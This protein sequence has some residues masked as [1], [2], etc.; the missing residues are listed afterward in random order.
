MPSLSASPLSRR[1][2]GQG[3]GLLGADG[4]PAADDDAAAGAEMQLPSSQA[5]PGDVATITLR[6]GGMM[7]NGCRGKV[8]RTLAAVEG[9]QSASVDLE[10]ELAQVSGSASAAALIAA[11][12][13]VGKSAQ[14]ASPEPET[15]ALKIGGMMCNGC[16]GKVE[17][18]L[19]AVQGV[20]SASVVLETELAHVT[21]T[22]SAKELIAAVEAVGKTA[23]LPAP[24]PETITL[25]I[26]GMVR[27]STRRHR[28]CL[29]PSPAAHHLLLLLPHPTLTP[30]LRRPSDPRPS[31]APTDVQ[32]LPRQG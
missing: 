8:E 24:E 13:A 17:K 12:E 22:A 19:A 26:G 3:Y 7:C 23:Q 4:A 1:R 20:Q 5:G 32:R 10:S 16:R 21:G 25:K 6:I 18:A 11:V 29:P 9:V 31:H 28:P 2:V 14:L 27:G 30:V 15:L